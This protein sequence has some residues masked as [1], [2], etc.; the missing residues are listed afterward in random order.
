M[1]KLKIDF[2]VH[3]GEDPKDRH[4]KYSAEQLLDKAAEYHFDAITITNHLS[5]LYTDELREYA[6]QRGILLI[7]GVE[8]SVDRK[9][10]LL[11]NCRQSWSNRLNFKNLRAY[12]GE[13]ALIIAPHPFYPREYCLKEEL[14]KHIEVFDAIEYAHLHFRFINFNKKAVAIAEKYNLP[15]VGTSD[16]H[17]LKQL[18]TTYSL[19]EAH[20]TI[21]AIIDAIKDKRVEV[22]TRPMSTWR[23]L[24]RGPG[25]LL[26]STKNFIRKMLSREP[27]S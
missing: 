8:V 23:L 9:H 1:K 15:M 18:N 3:T 16:A 25:F 20:K 17:T 26:S 19:V 13:N 22:V 5:V 27:S 14:E 12:A 21:P 2:H 10:V 24:I 11:V 4:I 7:P 6:E